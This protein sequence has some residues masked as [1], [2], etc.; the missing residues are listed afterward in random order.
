MPCKVFCPNRT[1][2]FHVKRDLGAEM[3]SFVRSGE[4]EREGAAEG[5]AA[6]LRPRQRG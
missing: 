5:V 1:K 4:C 3:F 6:S 2:M